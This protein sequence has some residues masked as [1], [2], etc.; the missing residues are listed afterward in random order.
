MWECA[1]KRLAA[2]IRVVEADT[3]EFEEAPLSACPGQGH[4]NDVTV[5]LA[6]TALVSEQDF[7]TR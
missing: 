4:F 2:E 3:E 5:R 6:E 1:T 7:A